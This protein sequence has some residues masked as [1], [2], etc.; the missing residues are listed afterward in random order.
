ML[1]GLGQIIVDPDRKLVAADLRSA[2]L[3]LVSVDS[4][5]SPHAYGG[6]RSGGRGH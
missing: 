3:R 6:H 4:D 2:H 1:S 5:L